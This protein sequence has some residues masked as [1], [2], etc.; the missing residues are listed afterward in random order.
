[1]KSWVYVGPPRRVR[2]KTT[3]LV[4]GGRLLKTQRFIWIRPKEWSQ[5]TDESQPFVY[6]T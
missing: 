5:L 4:S 6:I 1:M 3:E 2:M